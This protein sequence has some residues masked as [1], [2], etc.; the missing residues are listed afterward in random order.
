LWLGDFDQAFCAGILKVEVRSSER[1]RARDHR[2]GDS[3][4]GA[5]RSLGT[6]VTYLQFVYSQRK[7]VHRLSDAESVTARAMNRTAP[8]GGQG[9]LLGS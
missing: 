1:F 5:Y 3:L 2:V 9:L 6:W 7:K 8:E 4:A